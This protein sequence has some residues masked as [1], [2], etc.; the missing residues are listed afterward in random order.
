MI[1][2]ELPALDRSVLLA[3]TGDVRN[4]AHADPVRP[5]I[6]PTGITSVA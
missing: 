3:V 6:S 1:R 5:A 2:Q 4:E